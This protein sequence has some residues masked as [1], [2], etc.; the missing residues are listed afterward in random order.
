MQEITEKL[1]K[2]MMDE[3]LPLAEKLASEGK[4]A[5]EIAGIFQGQLRVKIDEYYKPDTSP[6]L[7]GRILIDF[8]DSLKN[9]NADSKAESIF[10]QML[11]E[12]NFDFKFQYSIGPYRVDYLFSGFLVLELDGPQ[13]KKE[14]DEER[15]KY[16]REM[17]YKIIRVPIKLLM[18]DPMAIIDEVEEAVNSMT[19]KLKNKR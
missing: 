11:M 6:K 14:H 8:L 15:D 18:W 12:K 10:Y 1:H 13:H 2:K 7:V 3:F 9:Q 19:G 4:D 5:D 16:M 17:G